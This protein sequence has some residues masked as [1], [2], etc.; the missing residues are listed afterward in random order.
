MVSGFS[1]DVVCVPEYDADVRAIVLS[2][3]TVAGMDVK[4]GMRFVAYCME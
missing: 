3:L 4:D 1:C 2:A